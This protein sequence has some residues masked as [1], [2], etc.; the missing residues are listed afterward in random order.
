MATHCPS[1]QRELLPKIAVDGPIKQK[2]VDCLVQYP[3]GLTMARMMDQIYS[4][5]PNGGPDGHIRA[6]IWRTNVVL[7]KQGYKVVSSRRG[8]GS[9]YKLVRV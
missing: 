4:D 2:I 6:M 3:E 9:K 1:C 5:D 7:K 8:P